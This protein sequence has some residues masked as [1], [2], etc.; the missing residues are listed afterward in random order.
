MELA[1]LGL[2][3]LVLS[4]IAVTVLTQNKTVAQEATQSFQ[5][6]FTGAVSR[7]TASGSHS[8]NVSYRLKNVSDIAGVPNC[9]LYVD[10]SS[11]SFPGYYETIISN[12]IGAGKTVTGKLNILIGA[13]G[14]SN[15]SRGR[16][17][18]K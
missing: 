12:E 16:I 14:S 4:L 11:G 15:V 8:V 3:V 10:D 7:V 6:T 2:V 9:S 5:S 1:F 17:T 18:C 13:P